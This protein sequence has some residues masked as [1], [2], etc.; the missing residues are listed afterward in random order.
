MLRR[1]WKPALGALCVG[2]PAAYLYHR[3]STQPKQTFNWP[4]RVRAADGKP[5]M[6]NQRIPLLTSAEAEAR[7]HAHAEAV[8]T[9]RQG[10]VWKQTTAFLASND[11][12]ED[13]NASK[14]IERD[15]SD[16]S[17]PGD[18][19]FFAVMDGHAG[20]FTSRLLS[21]TLIPSVAM[22]LA[23]L[24]Q[25]P[26]SVIPKGSVLQNLKSLISPTKASPV[27]APFDAN[28]EYIAQALERAFTRLDSEIV[29][30]PL[31]LLAEEMS[32]DG[33]KEKMIPNLSDHPMARATMLPA[34][35]GELQPD[36]RESNTR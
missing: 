27:T 5:V 15:P 10:V 13:A 33:A 8:S 16:V 3:F 6:I 19:L 34:M 21:K 14:I 31:R 1:A 11:P 35:S 18:F 12:I 32:R 9:T 30:S 36:G 26:A 22:E 28:P 20:P 7:L 24:I 23:M 25:E 4:V 2:V 17:P 29:D